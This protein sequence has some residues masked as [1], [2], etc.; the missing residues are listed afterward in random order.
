MIIDIE[1]LLEKV[2]VTVDAV[3]TG[4]HKDMLLPGRLTPERRQIIQD[5]TDE[6]Y[7]QFVTAVAEG[8]KLPES[9]VRELA[10]G[11]VYTGEQ[12]LALGLVDA[13]GGL[14]DA[15]DE[16]EKLAG[17]TD[18]RII[19]HTPSFFEQLFAGPGFGNIG[20]VLQ[21]FVLGEDVTLLREF[22]S[23]VSGPRYGG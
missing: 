21:G 16:A 8:R 2:G 11:Q 9:T 13:V 19:E 4:K 14:Q 10:T 15:I 6:A 3:T 22:L 7:G 1:G 20:A 5:I 12:A 17:I 18:A 23:G